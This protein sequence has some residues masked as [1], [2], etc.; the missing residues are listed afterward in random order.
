MPKIIKGLERPKNIAYGVRLPEEEVNLI[1]EFAKIKGCTCS[2]VLR[3][4]YYEYKEKYDLPGLVA[5]KKSR[6]AK[7]S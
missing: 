7:K 3:S 6:K 4:A 5:A 1:I 2:D